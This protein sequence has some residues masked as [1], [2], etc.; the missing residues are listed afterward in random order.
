MFQ[1]EMSDQ[2]G[3]NTLNYY[4]MA[5]IA[6]PENKSASN[7]VSRVRKMVDASLKVP[8]PHKIDNYKIGPYTEN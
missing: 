3:T 6:D 5:A 8:D 4:K 7:S 2:V 1:E